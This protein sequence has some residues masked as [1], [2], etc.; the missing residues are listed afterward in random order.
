[1]S[2]NLA[3][4]Q[5][6]NLSKDTPALNNILVGLGWDV[7]KKKGLFGGGHDFDLDASALVLRNDHFVNKN[8]LIYFGHRCSPSDPVYHHGDNLTGEG[9]GDDEQIT[10]TLNKLSS[11]V[12]KIVFVVNIYNA[13]QRRQSFGQ[14]SNAF[15][16]LVN[17]SN[18]EELFKYDLS[19][20]GVQDATGLIFAEIYRHNGDWKF[21]A[22]G[23]GVKVKSVSDFIENYR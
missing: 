9:E 11:D 16:R 21:S 1:M 12:T 14:V 23:E 10:V 7:N 5:K 2:V 18:G 13:Q 15:I 22:I 8:D 3:K 4:G 19:S 20:V 17:E 6:V